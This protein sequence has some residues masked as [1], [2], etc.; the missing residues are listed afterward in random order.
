M[1]K[2]FLLEPNGIKKYNAN[3]YEK[4]TKFDKNF[5][6]L[7]GKKPRK[8]GY[9]TDCGLK[10]FWTHPKTENGDYFFRHI[11]GYYTETERIRMLSC[12]NYEPSKGRGG[13]PLPL[14]NDF[15]NDIYIFIKENGF[16]IYKYINKIL[17][18]QAR[19]HHSYFIAIIKNIFIDN[20]TGLTTAHKITERTLPY[21]LLSLI[22]DLSGNIEFTKVRFTSMHFDKLLEANQIKYYSYIHFSLRDD[23]M[24]ENTMGIEVIK[25]YDHKNKCP[26]IPPEVLCTIKI[27]IDRMGLF[28][29]IEE[30]KKYEFNYFLTDE[31]IYSK[32][33]K[34]PGSIINNKTVYKEIKEVINSLLP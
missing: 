21:N 31:Q 12:D 13:N 4:I 18:G 29:Y 16:W 9:C 20:A 23:F 33:F 7:N 26:I 15:L 19:M 1:S 5:T 11:S 10:V 6:I 32:G 25:S 22:N 3:E 17:N 28:R 24:L 34:Y 14:T 30:Q 8:F 2:E 27:P